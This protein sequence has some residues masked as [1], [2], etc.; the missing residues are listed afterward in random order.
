MRTKARRFNVEKL[1]VLG[2]G[3]SYAAT[4]PNKFKRFDLPPIKQ[5]PL[6]K[7]FTAVMSKLNVEKTGWVN[8]SVGLIL[9]NWKDQKPFGKCG[10]EEAIQAH[11]ANLKFINAIKPRR[12]GRNDPEFEE[13]VRHLVHLIVF[14]LRR[15]REGSQKLYSE[16]ADLFFGD[17]ETENRIIT[18]NY[19]DVLDKSLRAKGHAL[20]NLYFSTLESVIF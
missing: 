8:D 4:Q 7:N 3:A 6:D 2:A 17:L 5:T 20:Q 1:F 16:F 9:S 11:A 19:D 18:F 14:Q 10:L 15:C 13:Y 12:K